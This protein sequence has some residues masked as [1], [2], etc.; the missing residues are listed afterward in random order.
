M[1]SAIENDLSAIIR[2]NKDSNCGNIEGS[3]CVP[4]FKGT[5]YDAIAEANG[6]LSLIHI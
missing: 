4:I 6:G 1:T 3:D 2:V 5:N